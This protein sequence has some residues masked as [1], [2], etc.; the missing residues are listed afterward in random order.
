MLDGVVYKLKCKDENIKEF[1]V[2]SSVNF[3]QRKINI[4]LGVIVQK[5][6]VI[7]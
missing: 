5:L 2:G 6:L 1:Y 7:I 4:K 3:N